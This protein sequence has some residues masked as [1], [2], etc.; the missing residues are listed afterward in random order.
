MTHRLHAVLAVLAVLS[1]LVAGCMTLPQDGQVV[2]TTTDP[3]A[4]RGAMLGPGEPVDVQAFDFPSRTWSTV[5]STA[6]ASQS[7]T[8]L[9]KSPLYAWSVTAALEPRFWLRG[10]PSGYGA[11]VRTAATSAAYGEVAPVSVTA[12]WWACA[13]AHPDPIQF[14]IHCRSPRTPVAWIGTADFAPPL[15]RRLDVRRYTTAR[16]TDADADRILSEATGVL[17]ELDVDDVRCGEEL[18]R[19][20]PVSVFTTG[21]GSIDD[22]AE[23]VAVRDLPGNVM[24]VN[25][26]NWCGGIIPNV[27]GCAAGDSFVAVR[28]GGSE[29]ILWAHEHGHTRGLPHRQSDYAIMNPVIRTTARGVNATECAAYSG[30]GA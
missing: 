6:S 21:D 9:G 12:D 10:F 28:L 2:A 7:F 26:I 23:F 17:Q 27:I 14:G 20:G 30:S 1:A 11:R 4:F 18:V 8:S 24:I 22:G 5:A 19:S 3:V 16:L 15:V 25:D 13:R 29:G